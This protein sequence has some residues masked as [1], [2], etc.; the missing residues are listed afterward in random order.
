V[1]NPDRASHRHRIPI[2]NVELIVEELPGPGAP[3]VLLHGFPLDRRMWRE[4]RAALASYRLYLPDLRGHGESDGSPPPYSMTSFAEDLRRELDHLALDRIVL[5]G[6]SMGGYIALAF[7]ARYP[8]R[9]RAL[10][11]LD[12]HPK[13]DPPAVRRAR[14]DQVAR[15]RM[16][17]PEA[18]VDE[19]T[20]RLLG[21]RPPDAEVTPDVVALTRE[22]ILG[23]SRDG[24][25]GALEGMAARPDSTPIL[26]TISCPTLV[27]V[28][29]AD[30]VT[31][32]AMAREMAAAI[33]RAALVEIPGAGHLSPLERPALVNA[34]L[35]RFL[36]GV[37]A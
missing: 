8:E 37:A 7:A 27:V 15:V 32:P 3:V 12:T 10:V 28:G 16:S 22:M 5:G 34:A 4:Q 6:L 1:T 35:A 18:V 13:A 33:P 31:P 9:L 14:A 29:S 2:E 23:T 19:L 11:L 30:T 24:I 26:T 20:T 25:V 36:A 21:G 17:G